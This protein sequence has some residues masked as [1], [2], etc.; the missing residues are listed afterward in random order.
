MLGLIFLKYISDAFEAKHAILANNVAVAANWVASQ[1]VAVA[2]KAAFENSDAPTFAEKLIHA[3]TAGEMAGGD[4]RGSRSAA[5]RVVCPDH[6]PVDLRVDFDLQPI[7]RL[8]E[9]H[10]ATLEPDFQAFLAR[11]PTIAD[12]TRR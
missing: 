1:E 9:I 8:A 10:R 12:P 7:V 4:I 2:V 5:V 6:P 3:L 11:V